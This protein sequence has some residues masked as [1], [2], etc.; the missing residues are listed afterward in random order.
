V[1]VAYQKN[2]SVPTGTCAVLVNGGERSL[3]ANLAAANTFSIDHMMKPECKNVID[4]AKFFYCTGFFLTVSLDSI[5]HVCKHS[6]ENNKTFALNLS[7][8]FLIQFFADQMAAVMLY[9]D[10]VFGNESEAAAYGAAKEYGDDLRTI[11]LKL[12]A[13]PKAS[14]T[15]PRIVVFT[16]GSKETIVACQGLISTFEVEPLP[17]ELLVDTNGAGDAFV[18][19][20][21]AQLIVGKPISEC[22]RAGNFAARTIIQRSGC[23]FPKECGFI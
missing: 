15:R 17:K 6:V 14:G 2:P 4:K 22:V 13:E 19:G 16:Q 7:A 10:Y 18:G 11:A 20:F 12:A 23:T 9:A 21:L 3:I 5:L 8:P 1:L